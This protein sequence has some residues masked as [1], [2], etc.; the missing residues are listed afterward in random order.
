M[1]EIKPMFNFDLNYKENDS[2]V[3]KFFKAKN[4]VM[5]QY[6]I[7]LVSYMIQ[8]ISIGN[9]ENREEL[10]KGLLENKILI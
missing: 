3:V 6:L 10:I 9:L 1:K 7:L 5:I 4:S 2:S 8:K